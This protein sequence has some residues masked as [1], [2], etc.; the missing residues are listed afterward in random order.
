MKWCNILIWCNIPICRW[1]DLLIKI[2]KRDNELLIQMKDK[3]IK[4]IFEHSNDQL[5]NRIEFN[6]FEIAKNAFFGIKCI[7]AR[8]IW[9]RN[10]CHIKK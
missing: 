2:F 6:C 8:N 3:R 10:I 5:E 1:Y 9:S 4:H 7:C